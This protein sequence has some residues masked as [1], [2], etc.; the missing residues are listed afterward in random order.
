MS[1]TDPTEGRAMS[2][3][4]TT[5]DGSDD[6]IYG[7]EHDMDV[8]SVLPDSK[9]DS[10]REAE[11]K[12]EER[13]AEENRNQETVEV[14][15]EQFDQLVATVDEMQD[16]VQ[17]QAA[18]IDELEHE[19]E[20]QD[21]EV[22]RLESELHA[23]VWGGEYVDSDGEEQITHRS[24]EQSVRY[25]DLNLCV[26]A[27]V[28]DKVPDD[29]KNETTDGLLIKDTRAMPV[30][31]GARDALEDYGERFRDI[32]QRTTRLDDLAK[33]QKTISGGKD[34]SHWMD[35]VEH[36]HRV[37]DQRKHKAT[38]SYVVLYKEDV[39]A[40]IGPGEKRASQLMDEWGGQKDGVEAKSNVRYQPYKPGGGPN[41]GTQRKAIKIDIDYWEDPSR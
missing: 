3:E 12:R 31:N 17:Q 19:L 14:P 7:T 2:S 34:T 1:T 32:E 39:A 9:P 41:D 21:E 23:W 16:T 22:G 13:E 20:Q 6:E 27:L 38:G 29:N 25:Q 5:D 35:V 8:E 18:R 26:K 33:E 15:R 40:A 37:Q 30:E 4:S 10:V 36:A 28:N 11:Q 24:L